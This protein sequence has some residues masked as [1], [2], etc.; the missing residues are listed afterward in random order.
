MYKNFHNQ[1]YLQPPVVVPLLVG[2]V[3]HN[4]IP[5]MLLSAVH[6]TCGCSGAVNHGHNAGLCTILTC[7]WCV[8]KFGFEKMCQA[9]TTIAKVAVENRQNDRSVGCAKTHPSRQMARPY[10]STVQL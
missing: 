1:H 6:T 2:I 3:H 5:F 7:S 9:G 10:F 4:I 8:A